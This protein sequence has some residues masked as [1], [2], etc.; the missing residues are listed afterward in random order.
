[1]PISDRSANGRTDP[2]SL[3]DRKL[4]GAQDRILCPFD[5]GWCASKGARKNNFTFYASLLQVI[6]ARSSV[7][8]ILKIARYSCGFATSDRT[9]LTQISAP[10][11]PINF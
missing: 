8:K 3:I 11:L 9:N 10:K 4:Q 5:I 6:F 2:A 7:A 1:M